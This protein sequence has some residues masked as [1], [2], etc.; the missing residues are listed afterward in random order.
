M[1]VVNNFSEKLAPVRTDLIQ[2][3]QQAASEFYSITYKLNEFIGKTYPQ[4]RGHTDF[5]QTQLYML[6]SNG[7]EIMAIKKFFENDL[8]KYKQQVVDK[9]TNFLVHLLAEKLGQSPQNLVS[10]VQQTD[11]QSLQI[12]WN[13]VQHLFLRAETYHANIGVSNVLGTKDPQHFNAAINMAEEAMKA[14][15]GDKNKAQQILMDY[16]NKSIEEAKNQ[17]K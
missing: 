8:L 14:A 17:T 11:P 12:I 3:A 9:D 5:A 6:K 16:L 4:F 13:S 7:M 1:D 10:L 2:K 15:G